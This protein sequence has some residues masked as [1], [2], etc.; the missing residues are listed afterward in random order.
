MHFYWPRVSEFVRA[1]RGQ[2]SPSGT[3]HRYTVC[4]ADLKTTVS[5]PSRG[6]HTAS[7]KTGRPDTLTHAKTKTERASGA[8]S[9]PSDQVPKQAAANGQGM[10]WEAAARQTA[11]RGQI[12]MKMEASASSAISTE[13]KEPPTAW[14]RTV[15]TLVQQLQA[16]G[17]HLRG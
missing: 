1:F 7:R 9:M 16:D 12:L 17:D 8:F 10:R 14:Q 2:P 13:E 4:H 15:S 6:A 11:L 3:L 5:P